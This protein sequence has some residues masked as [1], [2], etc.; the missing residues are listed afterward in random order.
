MIKWNQRCD[1]VYDSVA[2]DQV[3]TRSSE[4]QAEVQELSQSQSVGTCIVSGSSF[5]FCFRQSGFY[6]IVSDGVISGIGRKWKLSDS[7]DS[8]CVAL[9]TPLTIPTPASSLVKTLR[10]APTFSAVVVIKK[11]VWLLSQRKTTSLQVVETSVTVINSAIQDY[12]HSD[13]RK[14]WS[15]GGNVARLIT[16]PTWK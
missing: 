7:Y 2:Y 14:L 8:D 4:S 1:S 9:A 10:D 3:K 13:D 16:F 15:Y 6:L 11:L 12:N 5:L